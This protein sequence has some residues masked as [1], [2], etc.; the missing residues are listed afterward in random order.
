ML[1]ARPV[2]NVEFVNVDP[3]ETDD[4]ARRR[5]LVN[6]GPNGGVGSGEKGGGHG[7]GED[8]ETEG[9]PEGIARG[10]V[11]VTVMDM[12]DWRPVPVAAVMEAP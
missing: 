9:Q 12:A 2:A 3:D 4:R 6:N 11:V 5:S 10:T 1:Q 7:P 8:H